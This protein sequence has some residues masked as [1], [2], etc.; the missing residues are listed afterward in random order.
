[1]AEL[2]K[3]ED[4]MHTLRFATLIALAAPFAVAAACSPTAPHDDTEAHATA[5]VAAL[6]GAEE[7]AA[8]VYVLGSGSYPGRYVYHGAAYASFWVDLSVRNDAYAKEVGIVW[9]ND[10]WR[11]SQTTR[12]AYEATLGDGR[13][14]WGV[15]VVDAVI[16]SGWSAPAEIEYAAF[17]RMNGVTSW[18]PFR[19][20]LIFAGVSSARPLR[21]LSTRATL[22]GAGRP[23][24]T[25]LVRALRT[26]AAR[27]VFVRWSL[28]GWRTHAEV[29]ARVP[30]GSAGDEFAFA[31]P[32]SGDA[33]AIE[34]LVFA[35]RLEAGGETAWDNNDG[36]DH[37]VRLAPRLS[38]ATFANAPAFPSS[39]I[40]NL[41][42]AVET[43]LPVRAV[44]LLLDDGTTLP[45]S[46]LTANVN[47]R[48]GFSSSGNFF[49]ALPTAALS[50]GRHTVAIEAA[51]GPFVRRFAGPGVDVDGGVV[52]LG[53]T[54]AVP[55]ESGEAAWDFARS[56]AGDTL[57]LTDRR[58]L[59]FAAGAAPT[60]APSAFEASPVPLGVGALGLDGAGRVYALAQS[61][62]VRWT[63]AGQ[64]DRGFGREGVLELAGTYDGVALCYGAELDVDA[65]GLY[66]ID[67]CNTRLLRF[68][69]DGAFVD[70]LDLATDGYT[71]AL[72]VFRRGDT[73]WVARSAYDNGETRTQLTAVSTVPGAPMRLGRGVV[74]PMPLDHFA[75]T[76]SG[77]WATR[78]DDL[79][80][81]DATGARVAMWTGGG[82]TL[83]AP[84]TGAL[85]IAKRIALRPDGSVDVISAQSNRI[86]RFR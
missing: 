48:N 63:A 69:H 65:H 22:D 23:T 15:D 28:D 21:L 70:S 39:G 42:G 56:A 81:F 73:L 24:V 78:Q 36:A 27:R 52:A 46:E 13:E 85:G 8:A 16:Q 25:G 35:V 45:L 68:G 20:H 59:R 26:S 76:D 41:T 77:F 49:A 30:D 66:V 79:Y 82:G 86:E 60:S 43:A 55:V 62:L 6:G 1:M 7:R 44:T 61:R 14:R 50:D 71:F 84:T 29:E 4:D 80:R 57:V 38:S 18:S 19:N 72:H 34:E 12:A 2:R 64:I 83:L 9:T 40:K 37:H 33:A 51:A 75:V 74:I 17:A 54:L 5:A 58:V 67:S 3:S 53:T 31:I 47:E 32:I 10:G 11:T